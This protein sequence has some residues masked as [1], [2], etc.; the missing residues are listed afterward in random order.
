MKPSA[1]RS[2]TTGVAKLLPERRPVCRITAAYQCLRPARLSIT[3][4][5]RCLLKTRTAF[6]SG[7]MVSLDILRCLSTRMPLR[8]GPVGPQPVG[9]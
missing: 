3:G 1:T 2:A 4:L 8:Q 7:V 5:S 9:T 6:L